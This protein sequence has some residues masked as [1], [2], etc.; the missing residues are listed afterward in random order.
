MTLSYILHEELRVFNRGFFK[1]ALD[2]VNKILEIYVDT[3][4][5]HKNCF[6]IHSV[7]GKII[8]S[9]R[10]QKT[11]RKEL[12]IM[13][14]LCIKKGIR[15]RAYPH[16]FNWVWIRYPAQFIHNSKVEATLSVDKV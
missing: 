10:R 11:R 4:D 16:I 5:K 7:Q 8:Y 9:I 15:N 3:V 14:F 2:I 1:E 13:N 12:I 6:F